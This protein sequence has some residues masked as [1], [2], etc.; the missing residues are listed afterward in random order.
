GD[1]GGGDTELDPDLVSPETFVMGGP[2][3]GM[4]AAMKS[5]PPA[6]GFRGADG[7]EGG[8]GPRG[9][10]PFFFSLSRNSP[11]LQGPGHGADIYVDDMPNVPGGERVYANATQLGLQ[12]SDDINALIVFDDGD[13]IFQ[14]GIDQVLFSLTRDSPSL[15]AFGFSAADILTTTGP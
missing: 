11:S 13:R 15:T 6:A 9:G 3:G 2:L 10:D 4:A 14:P 7:G 8:S 5:A 12:P 1:V